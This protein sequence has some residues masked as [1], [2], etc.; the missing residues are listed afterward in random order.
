MRTKVDVTSTESITDAITAIWKA[1]K[2]RD[3]N[4]YTMSA[5][6]HLHHAL[7]YS[8]ILVPFLT[9]MLC[10]SATLTTLHCI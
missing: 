2:A 8:G 10:P 1:D 6:K 7:P 4:R 5:S 9:A 3:S